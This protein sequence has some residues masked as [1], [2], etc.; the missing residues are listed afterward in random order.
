[1]TP[2]IV[3]GTTDAAPEPDP[4]GLVDAPPDTA[5]VM[6]TDAE[7]SV[8]PDPES[9]EVE[10]GRP[11]EVYLQVMNTGTRRCTRDTGVDAT[12]VYLVDGD[13]RYWSSDIC[14]AARGSTRTE[15]GPGAGRRI[16]FTWNGRQSSSC[17]DGAP[18]GP[19]APTGSFQLQGRV[20]TVVGSPVTVT[21]VPAG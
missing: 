15:L 18:A 13:R 17:A 6:C 11:L 16:K 2:S 5:E 14:S 7:I 3:A 12:E 4:T 8:S 10:R 21:I 1:V 9:T 20:A 19:Y